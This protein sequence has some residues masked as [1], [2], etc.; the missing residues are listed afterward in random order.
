MLKALPGTQ[1]A[2]NRRDVT[3]LGDWVL[4]SG[5]AQCPLRT[6]SESWSPT[7]AVSAPQRAGPVRESTL[8]G[9]GSEDSVGCGS[10]GSLASTVVCEFSVP[11]PALGS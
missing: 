9:P 4:S 8:L 10:P 6:H 1:S 5:G 3:G 2:E 7:P 11:L